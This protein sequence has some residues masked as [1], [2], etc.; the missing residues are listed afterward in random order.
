MNRFGLAGKSVLI[1]GG[2]SGI[3][4]AVAKRFTSEGADV[5][6]VGRR[7]QGVDIAREVGASFIRADVAQE[8]GVRAMIAEA[9]ALLGDLDVLVLNA[10]IDPGLNPMPAVSSESFERNLDVNYRHVWWGLAHGPAHLADG[11]S[12]IVTSSTVA[13]YKVPNVSH[14]AAAKE[15][16]VSLV[17][18]AALELAHRGIRANAVLPGTTISEMTPLD[19]WELPVMEAMLPMGRHA[20]ADPDLVGLYQF[21]ACDESRY[22]TGQAIAADGGM[23]IGMSYGTLL[24]LG[25]PEESMSPASREEGQPNE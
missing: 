2:T 16:G 7:P 11:A 4:R 5:A 18:S 6:V 9:S 22:I 8:D 17:K 10:G 3:G 21:L 24:A 23:T 20:V 25:A 19:H 1:T 12:I 13:A 15:A 14:Y